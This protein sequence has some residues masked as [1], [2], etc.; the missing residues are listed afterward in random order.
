MKHTSTKNVAPTSATSADSRAAAESHERTSLH[1]EVRRLELSKLNTTDIQ[2]R[3]RLDQYVVNEYAARMQENEAL[4]AIVVYDDGNTFYVADGLHRVAAADKMQ[5][6][7]IDAEVRK[8]TRQEALWW[9]LTAN[10]AHG[11]RLSRADVRHAISVALKEFPEKSLNS[12]AKHIGCSDTT[13]N[14]VREEM[15]STSQ[16]GN[17][18]KTVGADGKVRPAKRKLKVPL[19]DPSPQM[20]DIPPSASANDSPEGTGLVPDATNLAGETDG[21]PVLEMKPVGVAMATKAIATL[22]TI[23]PGDPERQQALTLVEAWLERA[24]STPC[25]TVTTAPIHNATP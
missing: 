20:P 21:V 11:L 6:A 13:V 7:D 22:N 14:S 12:I 9:S 16:I 3:V 2:V 24:L 5:F 17:L 4:S 15:V 8:G 10:K 1:C 25:P 23:P 18:E 19:A